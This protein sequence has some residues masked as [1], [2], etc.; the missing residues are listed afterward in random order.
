MAGKQ[1][2]GFT[3]LSR[4]KQLSPPRP[5]CRQL[6]FSHFPHGSRRLPPLG[7]TRGGRSQ[8]MPAGELCMPA[9]QLKLLQHGSLRVQVYSLTLGPSLGIIFSNSSVSYKLPN[10]DSFKKRA[11]HSTDCCGLFWSRRF[12]QKSVETISVELLLTEPFTCH[13]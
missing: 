13:S 4:L 11:P 10:T 9:T 3:R 1:E 7:Q 2:T 6:T 8:H 12:F 5:E